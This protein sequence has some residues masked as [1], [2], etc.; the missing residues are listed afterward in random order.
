MS[1]LTKFN[2][3]TDLYVILNSSSLQAKP[4]NP[5]Y[6]VEASF[7]TTLSP[8]ITL[9][10][11]CDY[12]VALYDA[13]FGIT[14]YSTAANVFLI[15]ASCVKESYNG[16]LMQ[17]LLYKT[18]PLVNAGVTYDPAYIE[19]KILAFKTLLGDGNDSISNIII[20]VTEEDGTPIPLNPQSTIITLLIRKVI[21]GIY[22]N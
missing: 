7:K 16:G 2:S 3:N 5:L 6:P 4:I 9:D 15:K 11:Q 13:S 21:N 18:P 8:P 22:P 10:K 14:S 17:R 12:I 19:P 1:Y 20:E